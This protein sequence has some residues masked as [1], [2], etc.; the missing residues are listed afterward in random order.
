MAI[1]C[2]KTVVQREVTSKYFWVGKERGPIES[3]SRNEDQQSSDS[4]YCRLET[5]SYSCGWYLLVCMGVR[6]AFS[7]G[8][9]YGQKMIVSI[10]N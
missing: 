5:F 7:E 8:C 1:A 10:E 2:G 3:V 4:R 6:V 9:T